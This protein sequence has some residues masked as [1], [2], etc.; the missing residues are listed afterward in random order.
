MSYSNEISEGEKSGEL[1]W[2]T[3]FRY[4]SVKTYVPRNYYLVKKIA[5]YLTLCSCGQYLIGIHYLILCV[6]LGLVLTVLLIKVQSISIITS[7]RVLDLVS[8]IR[9][10]VAPNTLTSIHRCTSLSSPELSGQRNKNAALLMSRSI[11]PNSLRISSL[12]A[13]TLAVSVMSQTYARAPP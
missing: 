2:A 8:A 4:F 12:R 3:K 7:L 6:C 10:Q 1:N 13:A 5:K 11:L 9:T